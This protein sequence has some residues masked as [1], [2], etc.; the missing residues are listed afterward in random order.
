MDSA[1]ERVNLLSPIGDRLA[2]LRCDVDVRSSSVVWRDRRADREIAL[3][4]DVARQRAD[5]CSHH[6]LRRQGGDPRL[7]CDSMHVHLS[8]NCA[9]RHIVLRCSNW[10]I[11]SIFQCYRGEVT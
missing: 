2:A 11:S 8:Q 6:A 3:C 1:A 9:M 4:V 5:P 10:S 7:S